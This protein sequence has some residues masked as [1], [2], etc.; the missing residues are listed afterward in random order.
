LR[1][2]DGGSSPER[3]QSHII[4]THL[5]YQPARDWIFSGRYAW[6]TTQFNENGVRSSD[7]SQLIY[8]RAMW[9]FAPRWDASLQAGYAWGKG[10]FA[11]YVLGLEVG[12]QVVDNLWLSVGYN[13][14]G[15]DDDLL[16]GSDHLRRGGFLRLRYKFDEH[17]FK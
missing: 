17:L 16:S 3:E 8:G 7:Q 13:A 1:N 15:I 9:D 14:S 5:N 12:A 10:G 4:S 6:R 11:R 2:V